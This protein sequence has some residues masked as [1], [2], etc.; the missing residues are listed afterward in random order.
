M[1]NPAAPAAPPEAGTA[2]GSPPT[3]P[4]RRWRWALGGL[5]VVVTTALL[6]TFGEQLVGAAH[7]VAGR[8]VGGG[9][10]Y[11]SSGATAWQELPIALL[12]RRDW[13]P[14]DAV[15]TPDWSEVAPGL[16]LA[17]VKFARPPDPRDIDLVVVRIDPARWQFRVWGRADWSRAPV[18]TLAQEA[19][20]VLAVNAPYFAE[21]GPLGLVVSDGVSRNRQGSRRAAHFLVDRGGRPRIVNQKSADVSGVEQGFQGFPAIMTAG[22]TFSYLRTGG[23]GFDVRVADRR[24]AAC[25]TG[26]KRVLLVATDTWTGGLSLSELATALGALGCVD[27]MGFDGGASTAL[28]LHVGDTH[29]EIRGLDTVPVIVG[30]S[31]R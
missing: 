7:E 30:V 2:P 8:L 15:I 4:T 5:A 26:D 20:L 29:R 16:A 1:A 13:G 22:R 27:A 23:R 18:A 12:L 14:T 3:P 25:V 11:W 21:D 24:T 17:D 10:L 28:S 31:P 6:A 9:R 19:G